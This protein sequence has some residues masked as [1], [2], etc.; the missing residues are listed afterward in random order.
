MKRGA[1]VIKS[2]KT[3]AC[4]G[5]D[6]KTGAVVLIHQSISFDPRKK[7]TPKQLEAELKKSLT[8]IDPAR[9]KSIAITS[10]NIDK[11]RLATLSAIDLKKKTPLKEPAKR[12]RAM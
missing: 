11:K 12:P 3:T 1:P 10:L 8:H 4:V 9:K 7:V 6:K 5:Y 2:K